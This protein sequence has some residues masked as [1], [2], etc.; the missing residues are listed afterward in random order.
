MD[1]L[2]KLFLSLLLLL[3]STSAANVTAM[4]AMNSDTD[5]DLDSNVPEIWESRLRYDAARK[6]FWGMLKGGEG[7]EKP[8]I[9]KEDFVNQAGDVINLK[10]ESH[11]KNLENCWNTLRVLNPTNGKVSRIGQSADKKAGRRQ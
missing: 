11:L 8:I 1:L 5:S 9:E 2:R 6:S 10:V 4:V 3:S 7:S